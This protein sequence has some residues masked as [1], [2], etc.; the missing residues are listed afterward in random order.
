ME[1]FNEDENVEIFVFNKAKY[2]G[3]IYSLREIFGSKSDMKSELKENYLIFVGH[4]LNL[5]YR[6]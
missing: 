5:N 3:H 2:V 6:K 4:W 1:L